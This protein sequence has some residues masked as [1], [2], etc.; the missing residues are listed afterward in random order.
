MKIEYKNKAL[1]S[2]SPAA[3]IGS[4]GKKFLGARVQSNDEK[5]YKKV[6]HALFV[7]NI[8]HTFKAVKILRFR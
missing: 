2:T 6:Y 8:T 7:Y 4:Y 3:S 5:M 1:F